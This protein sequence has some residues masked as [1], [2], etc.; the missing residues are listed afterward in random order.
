MLFYI[1]KYLLQLIEFKYVELFFLHGLP[2]LFMLTFG[3]FDEISVLPTLRLR[4]LFPNRLSG[5]TFSLLEGRLV[6]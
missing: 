5:V 1:C 2:Y 4:K 3:I 6:I